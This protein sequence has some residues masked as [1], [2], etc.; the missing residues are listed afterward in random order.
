MFKM[1]FICK[2]QMMQK[3]L[4]FFFVGL[5]VHFFAHT[6]VMRGRGLNGLPGIQLISLRKEA[7]LGCIGLWAVRLLWKKGGS[8]F[9]P[10]LGFSLGR[11]SVQGSMLPCPRVEGL[12]GVVLLFV[13][14]SA[15]VSIGWHGQSV[16]VYLTALKYDLFGFLVLFVGLFAGAIMKQQQIDALLSRFVGALKMLLII[17]VV[18]RLVLLIDPSILEIFGYST[19]VFI[20]SADAMP[21]AVYYT[22]LRTGTIRNQ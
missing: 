10:L 2:K 20:R 6:L 19:K 22:Q 5:M 11:V 12:V 1:R 18:R 13:V 3:L 16:G 14:S 9:T 8:R 7:L 4:K 21:P 17:S 15:L